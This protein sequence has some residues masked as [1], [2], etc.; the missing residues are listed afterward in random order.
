MKFIPTR[1]KKEDI[2]RGGD[3]SISI[4]DYLQL[5]QQFNFSG[6]TYTTPGPGLSYTAPGQR[7]EIIGPYFR[8]FAQLAFKGDSIV[9]ACMLARMM[10][11][12]EVRFQYRRFDHGTPGDLFGDVSLAPLE[13]PWPGGTTGDLL[14]RA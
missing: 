9:F 6:T 11:F 8:S 3:Q 2:A 5:L 1:R 14:A 12:S 7:Q 4:D 10:L 13:H